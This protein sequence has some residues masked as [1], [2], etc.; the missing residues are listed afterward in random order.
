MISHDNYC[1]A[2]QVNCSKAGERG[3][4]AGNHELGQ[5]NIKLVI[6]MM[7]MIAD[8]DDDDD[9]DEFEVLWL[10]TMNSVR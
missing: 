6:M 5:L 8:R 7:M 4:L 3:S 2:I 10:G 9:R 1:M